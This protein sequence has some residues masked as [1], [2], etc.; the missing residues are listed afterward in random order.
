[1]LPQQLEQR[2]GLCQQI[3][4]GLRP[5]APDQI[6]GVEPGG[7]PDNAERVG[8]G[9]HRSAGKARLAARPVVGA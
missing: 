1:M 5:V 6:V 9:P 4:E 8:A 2:G 3:G 7:Q